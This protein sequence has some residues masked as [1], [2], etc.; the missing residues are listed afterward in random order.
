MSGRRNNASMHAV[1]LYQAVRPQLESAREQGCLWTWIPGTNAVVVLG[2][3]KVI[4]GLSDTVGGAEYA[5]GPP[6]RIRE[7]T[8]EEAAADNVID[9][10]E[11]I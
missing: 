2:L 4:E 9:L 6:L 5:L 11:P 10:R 8:P 7:A 1:F 3:P